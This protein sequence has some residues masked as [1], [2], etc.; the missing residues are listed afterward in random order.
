MRRLLTRAALHLIALTLSLTTS[1]CA[2]SRVT[3]TPAHAPTQSPSEP[4]ALTLDTAFRSAEHGDPSAVTHVLSV[5]SDP[6][7]RAD[8]ERAVRWLLQHP[9]PTARAFLPHEGP[10]APQTDVTERVI[11]VLSE[12]SEEVLP[13]GSLNE[14]FTAALIA[15][16]RWITAPG[17]DLQT[18]YQQCEALSRLLARSRDP[19][20]V[21]PLL[22]LAIDSERD[23]FRPEILA[24]LDGAPDETSARISN[25]LAPMRMRSPAVQIVGAAPQAYFQALN[26]LGSSGRPMTF[27][28]VVDTRPAQASIDFGALRLERGLCAA[29]TPTGRDA[30]WLLER[31]GRDYVA[32]VHLVVSRSESNLVSSIA[33]HLHEFLRRARD[34]LGSNA[35]PPPIAQVVR[36]R[37]NEI[38]T[39][40]NDV[41]RDLER[42]G[43][44]DALPR[45]EQATEWA[46]LQA[47]CAPP[48]SR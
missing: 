40:F 3:S 19:T 18:H 14:G 46:A 21:E 5:A 47:L 36:V 26:A 13:T 6:F 10:G 34:M 39:F 1:W 22:A 9:E 48:S 7:A 28:R 25:V 17:S 11:R 33:P 35:I 44:S 2:P 30:G 29:V 23:V 45:F 15:R 42:S 32:I 16:L 43:R 12:V 8:H 20:K 37:L 38:H 24:A 41:R 31:I 27:S 4:H